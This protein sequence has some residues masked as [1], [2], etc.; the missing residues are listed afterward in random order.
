MADRQMMRVQ[1]GLQGACTSQAG[2]ADSGI[3]QNMSTTQ[4]PRARAETKTS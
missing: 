1:Y 2:W 4:C 3:L